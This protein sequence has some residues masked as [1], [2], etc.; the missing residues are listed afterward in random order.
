MTQLTEE[1]VATHQDGNAACPAHVLPLFLETTSCSST[2]QPV[3]VGIPLMPGRLR[4]PARIALRNEAG[5]Q[6]AAQGEALACWSDGSVRWL[7]LDFM[8]ATAGPGRHEWGLSLVRQ[9]TFSDALTIAWVR[10]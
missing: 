7:L 5:Q 8:A 6:V 1:R 9:R 4:D 2:C 10:G 3:R